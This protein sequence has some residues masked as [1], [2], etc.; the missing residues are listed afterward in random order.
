[1]TLYYVLFLWWLYVLPAISKQQ[2][3]YN[4]PR[5]G[6]QAMYQ[7]ASPHGSSKP[8]KKDN[9][10]LKNA[11]STAYLSHATVP[12]IQLPVSVVIHFAGLK[13]HL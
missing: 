12:S 11:V 5:T 7:Q 9:I 10:V 6:T 3:A 8:T 1:M 4:W 13:F 2:N